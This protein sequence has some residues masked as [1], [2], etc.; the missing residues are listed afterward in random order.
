MAETTT[1]TEVAKDAHAEA[2]FPPFNSTTF[3]SQLVWLAI[4]F[5]VFYL[6]MGRIALPRISEILET[7]RSRIS[8]DLSEAAGLKQQ[9]DAAIAAY[10]KALLTARQNAA[11]IAAET[12]AT[13]TAD[14]DAKRHAAEAE[15]KAKLVTAEAEIAA[16]KAK[17][18]AEVNAIARETATSV[19]SALS[20]ATVSAEE[21]AAAV[22]NAA[23]R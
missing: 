17:A 18:L 11:A 3:A 6:V 1:T 9:T 16:I 5:G 7:R 21:I 4:F 12:R 22:E 23:A 14:V 19:V 2:S 10:E 13:L 20:T 15:L 8:K